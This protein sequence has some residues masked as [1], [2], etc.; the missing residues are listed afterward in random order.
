MA[1]TLNL[2]MPQRGSSGGSRYDYPV[3]A[4]VRIFRNTFVG[5]TEELTAVPVG[6]ADCF[7]ALGV[8][9]DPVDNRTGQSGAKRVLVATGVFNVGDALAGATVP[10]IKGPVYAAEDDTLTLTDASGE[11]LLGTLE[12]IDEEGFWV[13]I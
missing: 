12:A 11:W 6:H 3:E 2:K 9:V 8:A 13:R 5:L 1:A 7:C 4:G 10:N